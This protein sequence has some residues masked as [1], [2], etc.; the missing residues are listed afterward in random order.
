MKIFIF[1]NLPIFFSIL[2]IIC[3]LLIEILTIRNRKK[4]EVQKTAINYLFDGLIIID[5]SRVAREVN[6]K[7]EEMLGIQKG[8]VIGKVFPEKLKSSY[9]QNLIKVISVMIEEGK[10]GWKDIVIE[11][12]RK[13]ILRVT[14]IPIFNK[15]G[16]WTGYIFILHDVTREK[17][18]DKIKSEFITV[19][20]HK[21]RTPLSEV[22]WGME[23]LITDEK[24]QLSSN[25]RVILEDCYQANDR[26]IF[27]VNSLLEV[28][29]I[30]KGLFKYK[31]RFE[32]LEDIVAEVVQNMSKFAEKQ[33][34]SLKYQ[35][36]VESLPQVRIDKDRISTLIHSLL[37]NALKYTPKGGAVLIEIKKGSNFLIF[38]IRDTGMGISISEQK[39]IFTKFFRSDRAI[40]IYTEGL[41]LNLFVAKNIIKKHKGE[42]WFASTEGQGT[43]FYFKLPI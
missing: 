15:K 17:E 22:K 32:S 24:E 13:L 10:Q 36:P 31:F 27:E 20:A 9:F 1:Q 19:A 43:I 12:P 40:K 39:W 11:Q 4:T 41:G 21:L 38:S 23:L 2:V 16:K 33:G 35:E 34:V 8:K 29:E 7:A 3:L 42:I 5:K 14:P 30:E 37:D 6:P 26:I 28:S 18:I 25:Q